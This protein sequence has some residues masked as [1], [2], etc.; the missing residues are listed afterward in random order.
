MESVKALLCLRLKDLRCF[1]LVVNGAI[2]KKIMR[3]RPVLL[4]IFSKSNS[5]ANK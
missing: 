1:V 5:N 4:S 3:V 2:T